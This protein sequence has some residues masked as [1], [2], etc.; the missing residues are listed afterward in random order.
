VANVVDQVVFCCRSSTLEATGGGFIAGTAKLGDGWR[1][2]TR[3]LYFDSCLLSE[4]A[5]SDHSAGRCRTVAT[6]FA[7]ERVPHYGNVYPVRA[8]GL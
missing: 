1:R 5:V 2:I 3:Q 4:R 6:S 7:N 8:G